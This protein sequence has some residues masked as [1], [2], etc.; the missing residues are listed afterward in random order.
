MGIHH[1]YSLKKLLQKAMHGDASEL[2]LKELS[3]LFLAL[4]KPLVQRRIFAGKI[5]LNIVRMTEHDIT[6]DCIADLFKRNDSGVL[7]EVANYFSSQ[8]IEIEHCSEEYLLTHLKKLVSNAVNDGIFRL[9]NEADPALAKIIRNIKI[10]VEKSDSF[11]I[12]DFCGDQYLIL[13]HTDVLFHLTTISNEELN[14]QLETTLVRTKDVPEMLRQLASFLCEQETYQRKVKLISLAVAV[15]RGFEAVSA[16]SSEKNDEADYYMITEDVRILIQ[17]SCR[18]LETQMKPR[19]VLKGKVDESTFTNYMKTLEQVLYD[20][21]VSGQNGQYSYYE[22]LKHCIPDLTQSSYA[23]QHRIIFEYLAKLAKERT[24]E[25][26]K[27]A[28]I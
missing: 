14:H 20:E 5:S 11:K 6:C 22:Q 24:R 8:S 18:E 23:K 19:Y 13:K 15:K 1:T 28:G 10:A 7:V 9:Y 17:K 12:E 26:L 16:T 25:K 2:E 27:R 4:A 3:R 21:F